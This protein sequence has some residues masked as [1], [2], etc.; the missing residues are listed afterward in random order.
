MN[1][2]A[3][4]SREEVEKKKRKRH[5]AEEEPSIR[6][7]EEKGYWDEFRKKTARFERQKYPK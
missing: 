7:E 6:R 3:K 4:Q 5:R 2:K 1:S